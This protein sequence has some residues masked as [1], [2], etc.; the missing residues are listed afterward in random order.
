MASKPVQLDKVTYKVVKGALVCQSNVS[1]EIELDDI[2]TQLHV[3]Q[4]WFIMNPS[5]G[6]YEV[7]CERMNSDL[8]TVAVNVLYQ[9]VNL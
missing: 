2:Q 9:R 3:T 8:L 4:G 5:S 7:Y 1:V 6:V